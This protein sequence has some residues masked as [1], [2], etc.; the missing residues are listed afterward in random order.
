MRFF[1]FLLPLLLLFIYIYCYYNF[2]YIFFFRCWK[3]HLIFHQMKRNNDNIWAW[4]LYIMKGNNLKR[5]INN[6]QK[7]YRQRYNEHVTSYN[8]I[9]LHVWKKFDAYCRNK[10]H[11]INFLQ[12]YVFFSLHLSLSISK[13]DKRWTI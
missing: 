1:L 8:T 11:W 6:K 5:E 2:W 10:N 9:A 7:S 4:F 13:I 3:F 12:F